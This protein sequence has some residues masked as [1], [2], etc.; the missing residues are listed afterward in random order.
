MPI[1]NNTYLN[2]L[3]N[4]LGDSYALLLEAQGDKNIPESVVGK[5]S[6]AKAYLRGGREADYGIQAKNIASNYTLGIPYEYPNNGSQLPK[7]RYAYAFDNISAVIAGKVFPSVDIDNWPVNN[8]HFAIGGTIG[9]VAGITLGNGKSSTAGSSSGAGAIWAIISDNTPMGGSIAYSVVGKYSPFYNVGTGFAN[10][11]TPPV[12]E[13]ALTTG[14]VVVAKF[15]VYGGTAAVNWVEPIYFGPATGYD[16][17][18]IDNFSNLKSLDTTETAKSRSTELKAAVDGLSSHV[19]TQESQNFATYYKSQGYQFTENFKHL[20]YDLY[21]TELSSDVL[22]M[23]SLTLSPTACAKEFYAPRSLEAVLKGTQGSATVVLSVYGL[24]STKTYVTA[25]NSS[26]SQTGHTLPVTSIASWGSTGY[27]ALKDET[28][29]AIQWNVGEYTK[30]N[31]TTMTLRFL[32]GTYAGA[33]YPNITEVWNVDKSTAYFN[34]NV[35]VDTVKS[36][37]TTTYY[38]A[39]YMSA[40]VGTAGTLAD[41]TSIWIRNI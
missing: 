40:T 13:P 12:F 1:I 32:N 29:G 17:V 26:F 3:E 4:A 21:G 35:A 24:T 10:Y 15:D 18:V 33:F 23:Q 37:G 41:T 6:T 28:A 19:R 16:D 31:P 25:K 34:P 8:E 11:T 30:I 5:V 36:V 20:W 27:A 14:D 7:T 39:A 38:G 22:K 2:I 9:S